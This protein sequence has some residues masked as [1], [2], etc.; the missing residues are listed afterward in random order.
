MKKIILC[1]TLFISTSIIAQSDKFNA[2]MSSSIKEY[3]AAKTA[4][5]NIAI[6]QKFIRIAEAEKTEWLPYYYAATIKAK[7]SIMGIGGD[8]DE[9]ADEA[10]SL[11]DKAEALSKNNCEILVIKSMIATA[12][13][14]VDPQ[15]RYMEFGTLIN[16]YLAEAKKADANNPRPY[17]LE[18]SNLVNTPEQ[19]G[20]GCNAAKPIAQK[21]MELFN[22]FKP[23]SEIHPNWGKEMVEQ[24]LKNC[25]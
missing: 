16:K 19:Y 14:I 8:K 17:I 7:M 3:E 9:V 5:E 23:A 1:L 12:K 6:A 4:E 21:A 2:A 25:K 18:S 15:N 20:G 22:S 24:I 13:M 10:Q 11:I